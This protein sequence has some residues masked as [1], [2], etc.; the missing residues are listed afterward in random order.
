MLEGAPSTL[1][2]VVES[3]HVPGWKHFQTFDLFVFYVFV[4]RAVKDMNF[5]P[6]LKLI[7][8]SCFLYSLQL[9]HNFLAALVSLGS[10]PVPYGC[11]GM[12]RDA[13]TEQSPAAGSCWGPRSVSLISCLAGGG[14][15]RPHPHAQPVP[16]ITGVSQGEQPSGDPSRLAC[17]GKSGAG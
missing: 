4:G 5:S 10:S 8:F 7:Y 1:K 15:G 11:R 9:N 2:P 3:G 14:L 17:W 16:P 12:L 13:N 6:L